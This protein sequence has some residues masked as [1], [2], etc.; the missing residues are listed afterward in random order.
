MNEKEKVKLFLLPYAGGSSL[1][2]SH[3][4]K[5]LDKHI[6]LIPLDLPGRGLHF[7][8]P[9]CNNFQDAMDYVYKDIKSSI[10]DCKYGFFGYC[11]GTTMV[12]ELHKR[13]VSEQLKRPDFCILCSNVPPDT[14]MK[15]NGL[16]D[17][18]VEILLRDWL[19]SSNI[20]KED[21]KKRKYLQDMFNVWKS[22]S[23]MMNKYRFSGDI[24]K[25]ECN[26]IL[27]NGKQDDA[28]EE[29]SIRRWKRFTEGECREIYIEGNHDFLKT[30]EKTLIEVI[31]KLI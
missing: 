9:V 6:E 14:Y 1:Y 23:I 15:G 13:I 3:W 26:L 21:M 28:L 5:F 17:A 27:I 8:E 11:V 2:Y 24:C 18:P 22:D 19:N 29:E 7:K 20:K 25:F 31:N 12:Y 10:D 16:E 30:N 4:A